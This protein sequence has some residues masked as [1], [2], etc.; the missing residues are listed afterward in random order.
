MEYEEYL[1]LEDLKINIKKIEM[2]N[3]QLHNQ[4]KH[5]ENNGK[6]RGKKVPKF[7]ITKAI[8]SA[9]EKIKKNNEKIKELKS[10]L[11]KALY[12]LASTGGFLTFEKEQVSSKEEP[13]QLKLIDD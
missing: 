1:Y 4:I 6:I 7:V 9:L 2:E 13:A 5:L 11:E 8:D 3:E 10:K 12:E